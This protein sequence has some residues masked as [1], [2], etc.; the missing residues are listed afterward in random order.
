MKTDAYLCVKTDAYMS[1]GSTTDTDS[2]A[3]KKRKDADSP[4]TLMDQWRQDYNKKDFYRYSADYD[5]LN[6]NKVR[7]FVYWCFFLCVFFCSG[8]RETE[9]LRK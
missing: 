4:S 1:T 7:L 3:D 6:Y 9:R 8:R 5:E 2:S